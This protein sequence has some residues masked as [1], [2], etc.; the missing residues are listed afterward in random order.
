METP[1]YSFKTLYAGR[2]PHQRSEQHSNPSLRVV[3][4]EALFM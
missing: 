4:G 3:G 1:T 2:N